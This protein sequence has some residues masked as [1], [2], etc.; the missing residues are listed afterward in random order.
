LRFLVPLLYAFD[1][2]VEPGEKTIVDCHDDA[3][4]VLAAAQNVA[5]PS[6]TNLAFRFSASATNYL[7]QEIGGK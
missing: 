7:S 5:R 2:I 4:A 1:Q 6:V 3:A